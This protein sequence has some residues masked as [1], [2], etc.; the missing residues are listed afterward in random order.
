[1]IV[2][3]R[4]KSIFSIT[5]T[6][7]LVIFLIAST[8]HMGISHRLYI[9]TIHSSQSLLLENNQNDN[10]ECPWIYASLTSS[11]NNTA[12]EFS[13]SIDVDHCYLVIENQFYSTDLYTSSDPRGPPHKT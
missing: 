7:W 3:N 2:D 10:K 4:I 12:I 6:L 11:G 13:Y 8:S 5:T 9:P 1:M